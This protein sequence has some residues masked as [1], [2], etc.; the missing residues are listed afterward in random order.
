MTYTTIHVFGQQRRLYR[1][2]LMKYMVRSQDKPN[3]YP[4][5]L[6]H[7]DMD[8]FIL[9]NDICAKEGETHFGCE[10]RKTEDEKSN[11]ETKGEEDEVLYNMYF[12]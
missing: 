5:Y 6:V 11:A 7:S 10:S 4:L 2:S 8:F 1:E 12:D 3:N 9:Y